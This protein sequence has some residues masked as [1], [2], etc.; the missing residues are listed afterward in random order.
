MCCVN[1]Y[2]Q[3]FLISMRD[4]PLEDVEAKSVGEAASLS[5]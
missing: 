3:I 4:K 1:F 2:K 5:K